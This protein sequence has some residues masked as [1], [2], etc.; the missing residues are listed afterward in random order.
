[1]ALPA[2]TRRKLRT[3]VGTLARGFLGRAF[4]RGFFRMVLVAFLFL[5]VMPFAVLQALGNRDSGN[6]ILHEV[7][8][9]VFD[10]RL[11][12]VTW[13]EELTHFDGPSITLTGSIR[14]TNMRVT[15][16]AGDTPHP[17]RD[18]L[19]YDFLTVPSVVVHYDLK[20][21]PALPVTSVDFPDGLTM[22]FNIHKGRW[23]DQDL[24]RTGGGGGET[25][26]L[27]QITMG[28]GSL[29]RINLRAD[30]ILIP[31]EEQTLAPGAKVADWYAVA[32]R[33]LRLVPSDED[34]DAFSI[35][36]DAASDH[37][38]RFELGGSV[39]RN[40]ERVD[41][42]FRTARM[43]RFNRQYAS[44]LAP[45]VRRT[46]EQFQIDA[47]LF[48]DARLV[49]EPGKDLEFTAELDATAGSI[50]FVGFPLRVDDVTADIRVRNNNIVVDAVGRRDSADV[51]VKA[52]VTGIGTSAEIVQVTV[53][54]KDLLIDE[55]F[56]KAM[57]PS[58][59]QRENAMDYETGMPWPEDQWD[60]RRHIMPSIITGLPEIGYPEWGGPRPWEG[61]TLY[62]DL[63]P[64][65]AFVCRGFTPMGLADFELRLQLE[66]K[67]ID[68]INGKRTV[69]ET[70][71]FKVFVRDATACFTGLPEQGQQGFPI[72]LHSAY[73][74]VEGSSQP[75]RPGRYEVRGYTPEELEARGLGD[76]EG[77]TAYARRGLTGVL[78]SPSERVWAHAVY[79]D[80]TG[81]GQQPRLT[82]KL[83]SEG[84]D[85]NRE[86][87]DRLPP[88][89]RE[90]VAPYSPQG[91][92]D[93]QR[94]EVEVMPTGDGEVNFDFTLIARNIAAQYQ[95]PDAPEPMRFREISGN[96]RVRSQNGAVD[97][98][99]LRG[100]LADN[101]VLISMNVR[102]NGIPSFTVESDDFEVRPELQRVVPPAIGTVLSRFEPR[103]FVSMK[104]TG[105]RDTG[106]ADFTKADIAFIAG[107][108]D[109]S[110]SLRFDGFPYVITDVVGRLFVSV[111]DDRVEVTVRELSGHGS[112]DS[113]TNEKS[114]ITVNGHILVPYAAAAEGE[115]AEDPAAE[116]VMPIVDLHIVATRVPADSALSNAL[117]KVFADPGQTETPAIVRFMESLRLQG[118]F[119]VNGRLVSDAAGEMFWRFELELEG[120]SINFEK[121]P[122]PITEL[123]GTVIIDGTDV[124]LRNVTG[125]VESGTFTLHN[126]S[127]SEA[128]GWAL[129][130]SVR[131]MQFQ[132]SPLLK[133]ALPE[134]LRDNF[135][136]LNPQGLFDLDLE[137]SGDDAIM[138]YE[139]SLDCY[140]TDVDV[141]LH[142]DNMTARFDFEGTLQGEEQ[143]SNG[144]VFVK[145]IFFKDA[146]FNDV[147][148]SIQYFG[149]RLEFPN[150]RGEFYDGW[151]EGRFGTEG[152]DYTG[153]LKVRA[154]DLE[155]LGKTAFPKAGELAGA[156]DAEIQFHSRPDSLGQIGSGRIDVQPFDRTS[157]DPKRNTC[158]LAPVPLF[159]V[160]AR[161]TGGEQNF[162]EGHVFFWLGPD[163]I[164][165]R[166]MDFISDS[167]RVETFG[168]DD[169]N[170]I[171][172]DTTQMRMKLFFTL[173]P[174]APIPLPIVQQVL[175]LLK[176]ILFPLYVTGTL[177]A[178]DVQ[179]F[180]LSQDEL[181][182]I[183]DEFPRRPR[184]R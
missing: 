5:V 4:R 88:A 168:G 78:S 42:I 174:R 124:S 134:G 148:S 91:K 10:T 52:D 184:G 116:D 25:P 100:R 143:R 99:S 160:I 101:P 15:R 125:R 35:G 7:A 145:E 54:I 29:A 126:A 8:D 106:V 64:V 164:T 53:D 12:A 156:L 137:L 79:I 142:F 120:P 22:Y 170:Y 158:K 127:Y 167:A 89:V 96:L 85:F 72:P 74:V 38:G 27:P 154:A 157:S 3:G 140:E 176:Q 128:A 112:F 63:D 73:G 144:T 182:Q 183:R 40:G 44:V 86:F 13:D 109:R 94:A 165:I 173:A 14:Y 133:R 152:E 70:M 49:I 131:Q 161:V 111:T 181:E 110:G 98:I 87:M 121:F 150:L 147:T 20:R 136:R 66:V 41:V 75:G 80:D 18:P 51:R 76:S 123:Y 166:E 93:I 175:D 60:P 153:E 59:L 81:A 138:H 107:T 162:D 56:R 48:F 62:P 92:V 135:E 84:V 30:G 65:F 169:A 34:R 149:D 159:D 141:G 102:D 115:A 163:R 118:T 97:L 23:L 31:P 39:G 155:K 21:L 1:M 114:R 103:G 113:V 47:D 26:A 178:P 19:R 180:S 43:Q 16:R 129:T 61:A 82:L 46:V 28:P 83:E 151:V 37:F 17:E 122:Y 119:G 177:N 105:R 55:K 58:R 95:F 33:N 24:F 32:L 171:D 57:L 132:E 146:R 45:D 90:A 77:L 117:T 68:P 71:N 179:P 50:C 139:V 6:R 130:L 172:Y 69:E 104:V 108:G 11:A 2:E 36:G 9:L 67:G